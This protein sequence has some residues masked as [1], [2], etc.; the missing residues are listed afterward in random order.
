MNEGTKTCRRCGESKQFAQMKRDPRNK[1]GYSSFCKACHGA[2]TVAWQKANPERLNATRK[3]RYHRIKDSLNAKRKEKYNTAETRAR[4]R[5]HFYKM[6][7]TRYD[8]LLSSQGGCCALCG[9]HCSE[10]TR[11]LSVDHDHSCCPAPPT[12]GK[13]NRGLLCLHCNTALQL[14]ESD[15]EWTR[16]ATDYLNLHG[17][18]K[19]NQQSPSSTAR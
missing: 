17:E 12:C 18:S 14:I 11:T 13:C 1:D 2:A 15:P 7:S 6:S 19:W 4:N 10:F 8:E 16:K 3:V 9:R 5:N